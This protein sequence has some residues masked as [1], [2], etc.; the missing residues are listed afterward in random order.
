[1]V[2]LSINKMDYSKMSVKELKKL[3]KKQRIKGYS[4]MKKKELV[5]LLVSEKPQSK[6][7]GPAKMRP[8]SPLFK[9]IQKLI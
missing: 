9:K 4:K 5:E 6:E 7:R 2:N 1:M 8:T 3:C